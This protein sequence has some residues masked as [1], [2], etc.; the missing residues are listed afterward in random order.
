[1]AVVPFMMKFDEKLLVC[2]GLVHHTSAQLPDG[3][4]AE[5]QGVG[6]EDA[7]GVEASDDDV[8]V[9]EFL[10]Q[11]VE[12]GDEGGVVLLQVRV[13]AQGV[14]L[15]PS[16]ALRQQLQGSAVGALHDMTLPLSPGNG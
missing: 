7:A 16:L 6:A 8:V 2:E 4:H 14:Q 11:L 1:M 13:K 12:V 5:E 15:S 3:L 10:L 9:A